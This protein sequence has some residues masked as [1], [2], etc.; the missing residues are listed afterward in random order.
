LSGTQ[1]GTHPLV[2]EGG[3]ASLT[4]DPASERQFR[5]FR[6]EGTLERFGEDYRVRGSLTGTLESV[7]DRCLS[8]FDREIVA[9][10]VA[11]EAR[12]AR[13]GEDVP[14]GFVVLEPSSTVLDLS[15]AFREAALLA[16]P[17]KNVC[18]DDCLG[19]CPT[20][21]TNRNEEPCTCALSASDPRWDTLRGISFP[22]D[23]KE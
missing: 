7:C 5:D 20:C 3:R 1:E 17:M 22:S 10:T 16:V 9:D 23:P 12:S 13:D 4:I 21:G 8:R 14:E 6:F 11:L 19:I 2:L 18:R 15:D